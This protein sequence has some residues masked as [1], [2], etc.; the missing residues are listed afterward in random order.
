MSTDHKPSLP[1]E[2]ARIKKNGGRIE[3]FYDEDGNPIGPERVWKMDENKPGLA[4]SRSFGDRVAA[5]LGVTWI[6]EITERIVEEHD[7]FLIMASDGVWEF[8]SNEEVA[9]PCDLT[10]PF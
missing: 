3:P 4:M 9:N 1:T 6:P 5:T 10:E 7:K 8:I 2:A